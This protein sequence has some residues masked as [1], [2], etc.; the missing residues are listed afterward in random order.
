MV[1]NAITGGAGWE[2]WREL[3]P[4]HA[5]WSRLF[6]ALS[7]NGADEFPPIEIWSG[8]EGLLLAARLP[9]LQS[10]DVDV[11]VVGDTLTLAGKRRGPEPGSGERCHR[12]E[13]AVGEFTRT[14]QL[15]FAIEGDQVRALFRHGLL[16]VKLPRAAS[17]RPRK[18]HVET[19]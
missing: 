12:R 5:P 15:P 3:H 18:I 9:G 16:E 2:A 17:E 4:L 19:N 6:S 1:W 14:I 10:E 7:V 8:D 11:T 13:R